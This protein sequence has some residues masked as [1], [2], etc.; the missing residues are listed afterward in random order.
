M[1][2]DRA[3]ARGGTT[4]L[5]QAA[6]QN[7]P[8]V[9][10]V[11]LEHRADANKEKRNGVTPLM[12]AAQVGSVQ[13]VKLLLAAGADLNK[14]S[15]AG[16]TPLIVASNYGHKDVVMMLLAAGADVNK[17]SQLRPDTALPCQRMRPQGLGD[18]ASRRRRRQEGG[19]AGLDRTVGCGVILAT[20]RSSPCWSEREVIVFR[21]DWA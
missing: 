11:L 6:S 18:D 15:K 8:E 9:V 16:Q 7:F 12:F 19:D 21:G 17:A 20:A 10:E 1:E 14:A 5:V 13:V 2:V 4:P 3:E